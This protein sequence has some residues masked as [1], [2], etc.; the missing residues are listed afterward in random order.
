MNNVNTRAA[1]NIV[2]ELAYILSAV[3]RDVLPHVARGLAQGYNLPPKVMLKVMR[4][5]VRLYR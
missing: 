4:R 1:Y 2:R 3:P 5:Y